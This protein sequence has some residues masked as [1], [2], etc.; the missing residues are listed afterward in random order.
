M[1]TSS[2]DLSMLEDQYSSGAYLKRDIQ[3]VRGEGAI[4]YD[5]DGNRYIDCV[6]G[7]GTANLGHCHPAVV[8]AIQ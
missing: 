3:I 2:V 6:G 4:L 1:V 5:A 8:A 7:Q